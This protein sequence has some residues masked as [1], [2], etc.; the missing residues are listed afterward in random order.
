MRFTCKG[1]EQT[2][3]LKKPTI[4]IFLNNLVQIFV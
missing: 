3:I 4:I 2:W 1:A